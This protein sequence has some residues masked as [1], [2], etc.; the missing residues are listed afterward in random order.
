[1]NVLN[2][3]SP[4]FY[5]RQLV[6][7]KT[8]A[9]PGLSSRI[10]NARLN[11]LLRT[12]FLFCD[13]PHS[14]PQRVQLNETFGVALVVNGIA[15]ECREFLR[16]KRIRRSTSYNKTVA[17]VQLYPCRSSYRLL[18]FI[19]ERSHR[20]EFRCVPKAVINHFRDPCVE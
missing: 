6:R 2:S 18:T 15:L 7:Q 3:V 17:F 5:S 19:N 9:T 20:I 1:M 13:F 11:V 8:V 4:L 10:T 16:V 14:Q 12:L